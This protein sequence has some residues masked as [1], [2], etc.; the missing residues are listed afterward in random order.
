M[1]LQNDFIKLDSKIQ[2]VLVK[3][4]LMGLFPCYITSILFA[5]NI[6]ASFQP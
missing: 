1:N 5:Y 2:E 6:N 4:A 3:F